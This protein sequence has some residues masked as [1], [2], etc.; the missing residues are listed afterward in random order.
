LIVIP[1]RR[2]RRRRRRRRSPP[3][4]YGNAVSRDDDDD[5]GCG[6]ARIA[7]IADAISDVD[8][9]TTRGGGEHR[10]GQREPPERDREPPLR[11][12]CPR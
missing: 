9:S 1:S 12:G 5:D 11:G 4:R 2:R 3:L 7:T 8:A 10:V 6:T